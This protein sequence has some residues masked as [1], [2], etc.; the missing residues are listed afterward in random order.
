[1]MSMF[2]FNFAFTFTFWMIGVQFLT[3]ARIVLSSPSWLWGPSSLLSSGYQSLF[4]EVKWPW[5][6]A[7]HSFHLVPRLK[8]C[9]A[10]PP[11]PHMSSWHGA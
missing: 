9:G 8:I 7:D 11:V 5:H 4:P 6:E 10:I 3:G 1:M 2:K